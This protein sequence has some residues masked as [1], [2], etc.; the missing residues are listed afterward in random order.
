MDRILVL[1]KKD[2]DVYRVY[3]PRYPYCTAEGS[4]VEEVTEKIKTVLE[5]HLHTN[6]NSE[7]ID[8]IVGEDLRKK[9]PQMDELGLLSEEMLLELDPAMLEVVEELNKRITPGMTDAEVRQ[10]FD[11]IMAEEEQRGRKWYSSEDVFAEFGGND[12]EDRNPPEGSI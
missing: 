5:E 11:A 1:W 8:L 2:G 12:L 9:H 7:P 6:G 4:S 10:K 3:S